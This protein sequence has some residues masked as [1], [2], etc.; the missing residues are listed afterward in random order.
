MNPNLKV[1]TKGDGKWTVGEG[2]ALNESGSLGFFH[3][4]SP[5]LAE[6]KESIL[7][8]GGIKGN[9][10]I[11]F[12]VRYV[13]DPD[14][15]IPSRL[16]VYNGKKLIGTITHGD[17][18][19]VWER[20]TITISGA[21]S[22][23]AHNYNFIFTQ[24][25]DPGTH[26]EMSDISWISNGMTS[27]FNVLACNGTP[28]GGYTTG[29]GPYL[30]GKTAKLVAKPLPGWVFDGWYKVEDD[31][32]DGDGKFTFFSSS[33]TYSYKVMDH[34]YVAAF[35]SKIPYVRGLA[36]PAD[37]GK[38]TGSGLCAKGKKVTLKASANKN[39]SF[40]GWYASLADNPNSIDSTNCVA[41]TASLVIDR[42]SKPAASSKTSTTITGID[43]DVTYYAVFKGDPRVTGSVDPAPE[44][45]KI[46][47]SGRY[48]IGK[49]V[50]IRATANK[51]YVFNGWYK[52][53]ECLSQAASYVFNMPEEDVAL[54]AK[55]ITAEED[56][57]SIALSVDVLGGE[58]SS[59]NV[60]SVTNT[61][62]VM[63]KWSVTAD[64][65]SQPVVAVSGLPSG[66]K[67]TAKDIMKKG[68]KTEVEIP[69]NTVYGAPTA[70]SKLD[71]KTGLRKPSAVKFTV[72]TAG[73]SKRVYSVDVTVLPLP[74][75]AVG[76][77][78]GGGDLGQVSLTVSKTGKLS[79][80]YL[81]EGLAW[82]L[83]ADSFDSID[84]SGD[85][86]RATLIGKSGKL[87][88]TNEVCVA[89]D[90]M[91]GFA[92]S[93]DYIAYTDNWKL[94]PWKSVGKPFAKAAVLEY[95]DSA[96]V[97]GEPVSG[98]LSLKFAA[99][100][101]V[102]VK[103]SF[104]TG[105]NEKTGKEILYAA[106]GTA[107]VVPQSEPEENGAFN[108]VVFVYLPPKAGKFDGYVRSIG[109]RWTGNGWVKQ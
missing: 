59:E 101:A 72:T 11:T 89:C 87:I 62:G 38:V 85:V 60:I 53:E 107:V 6:G 74:D 48:A 56:A 23:T 1:T 69:S 95:E 96:S 33:A 37:G 61:C 31:E 78:N 79:G 102:T 42:T 105:V 64:A 35:F 75:W 90:A 97:A 76:T 91:G 86:Y 49:K 68:S 88:M 51:G 3:A 50:T 29:S 24:G 84:D 25:S 7:A 52:G 63:L 26:V 67:F 104:V 65:L 5:S 47:G 44:A 58:I 30:C 46:T 9:G 34:L 18:T 28:E 106:S 108:A 40:V 57:A 16:D 81:S 73:K 66:L 55:F 83:A 92:E 12:Y 32:E 8:L 71:A 27:V 4:E 39:F 98:V 10:V 21:L 36:D 80:K 13:G 70:E 15:K 99:S 17:V 82:S 22:S 109:I 100:G 54:K 103:G 19:N 94:E 45:G 2:S 14:E 93:V 77:F 20:Y 41:T 43:G